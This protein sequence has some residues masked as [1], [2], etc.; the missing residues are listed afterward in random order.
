MKDE[1]K[2]IFAGMKLLRM[3]YN[4]WLYKHANHSI[5]DFKVDGYAFQKCH[6]CNQLYCLGES[7]RPMPT[8]EVNPS[9]ISQGTSTAGILEYA[10]LEVGESEREL[11]E[12]IKELKEANRRAN[13]MICD[14]ADEAKMLSRPTLDEETLVQA[15]QSFCRETYDITGEKEEYHEKFGVLICFIKDVLVPTFVRPVVSVEELSNKLEC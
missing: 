7:S 3:D 2:P 5:E 11:E 6:K 10:K 12:E 9:R 14:M 1:L 4:D 8:P 15:A 13:A